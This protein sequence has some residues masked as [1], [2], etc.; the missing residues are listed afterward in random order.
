MCVCV[1]V[2]ACACMRVCVRACVCVCMCVRVRACVRACMCV[3]VCVCVCVSVCLCA[4]VCV[5]V[6]VCMCVCLCVRHKHVH[7]STYRIHTR[8]AMHTT[9]LRYNSKLTSSPLKQRLALHLQSLPLSP[10]VPMFRL[11]CLT[12]DR[13]QTTAEKPLMPAARPPM[14]HGRCSD[15]E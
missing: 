10:P 11:T 3:C 9:H 15:C 4:C 1:Y 14:R 8:T 5:C 7:S 12:N 6:C 13:S 2:C